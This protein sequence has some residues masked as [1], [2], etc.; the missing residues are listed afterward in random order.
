MNRKSFLFASIYTFLLWILTIFITSI[1][2]IIIEVF[3]RGKQINWNNEIGYFIFSLIFSL[4]TYILLGLIIKF[5]TR[6][7]LILAFLLSLLFMYV[8]GLNFDP[9]KIEDYILPG[10]HSIVLSCLILVSKLKIS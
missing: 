2:V 4:P 7:K 3:M 8:Y 6:N 1:I 10:V 9:R 5:I